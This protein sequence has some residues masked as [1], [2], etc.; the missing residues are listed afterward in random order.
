LRFQSTQIVLLICDLLVFRSYE[1]DPFTSAKFYPHQ[2]VAS[3]HWLGFIATMGQLTSRTTSVL[4][5][6]NQCWLYLSL[7]IFP[8]GLY[9]TSLGKTIYFHHMPTLLHHTLNIRY[10]PILLVCCIGFPY[11]TS[12]SSIGVPR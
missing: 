7:P 10:F 1:P 3:S 4:S 6:P 12:R 11:L 5:F 2:S 8:V 9:E